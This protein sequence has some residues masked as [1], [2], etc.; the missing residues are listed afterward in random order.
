MNRP[1]LGRG[2]AAGFHWRFPV[3]GW[4]PGRA[5]IRFHV[6]T[7]RA[8][9]QRPQEMGKHYKFFPLYYVCTCPLHAPVLPFAG[10]ESHVTSQPHAPPPKPP[11]LAL[12]HGGVQGVE[13]DS[14]PRPC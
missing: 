5:W 3:R 7:A 1:P 6:S 2:A 8:T 14:N 12:D 13:H 10:E 11:A 9:R 4:L